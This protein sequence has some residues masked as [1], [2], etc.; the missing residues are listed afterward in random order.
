MLS[1]RYP[2]LAVGINVSLLLLLIPISGW[3]FRSFAFFLDAIPVQLGV[4]LHSTLH[5]VLEGQI[6]KREER[7]VK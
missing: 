6:E 7:L 2:K 4:L 1:V 5:P 3:L